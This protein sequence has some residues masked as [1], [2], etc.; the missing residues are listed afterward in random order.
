M[1][2]KQI[3]LRLYH[4]YTKK[5]VK[6]IILAVIFSILVAGSMSSIAWLLD[7]AINK[8]FLEKDQTL[9][10][11]IPL[12]I[13][14]AFTTKG[15]SLY[16]AKVIMIGVGEEVKKIIQSDMLKSFIKADT[17]F[18]ENKHTG[19]YISN[20]TYDVNMITNLLS[21][22]LLNLFK[23]SLTLIGLLSVMFFQNWKLSLI[24]LIMI[25][26]ASITARTLGKRMRKVST[27]AQEK[28]GYLTKYL[29]EIFKNHKLI[30]IFQR[31]NYENTRADKYIEELKEKSKKIAI[32]YVRT[33]PIME[34]MTGIIIAILIFYSGKLIFNDELGINNFFSF[35]AAMMLA[36]QPV[37]ALATLNIGINQGI[38]AAKRIL[39]I[40]DNE[41]TILDKKQSKDVEITKGKIE[42]K[43]VN[44]KYE[45]KNE[46][47]LKS[48]NLSIEGGKM[49]S[50]VGHSGAGK[51]TILNLIPRFYDVYSGDII[52]DGN[53]IYNLKIKSLRDN[54]SLVSQ[55]TT[56]FDDT[57]RNNILYANPEAN[58]EDIDKA[59]EL[60]FAKDFIEKLPKKYDTIIG[61]NGV[62]LSG[63]EK[64]RLSI[65]RAMLKKSK[66]VLLDE[67]TSSLD[68]ETE[69][70]IQE[71]INYLTKD[72]TTLVIA[73][74]LSTILNSNKIFVVEQGEV[75][76]QGKHE[77]LI[78]N[79]EIY[80]NFYERQIRKD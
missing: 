62:T 55:D 74:R 78:K 41:Q 52:L 27:E 59:T 60:S 12:L 9:I 31:E 79:S 16:F 72:R 66:I 11:V 54:I 25:P 17:Q 36:Y 4:D 80:K 18:I 24:A 58:D 76:D 7:P 65:A 69:N 32:V 77:D 23:D 49:S 22:T 13:I 73:H 43:N 38:S 48:L 63:G 70:K 20:L 64:Q 21:N 10:F 46:I 5:F 44:F 75:I 15:L 61:E 68:S 40:I 47:V 14:L 8:I 39:P 53:S 1:N 30:K 35:L 19:K 51:S 56:L 57:V 45:S 2:S 42:F 34:T 71:A 29:I 37:R 28:S 33:A 26:F 6:K 3:L 67:A 50:L